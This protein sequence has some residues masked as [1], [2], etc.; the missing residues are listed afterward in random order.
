MEEESKHESINNESSGSRERNP[1]LPIP[2]STSIRKHFTNMR[3]RSHSQRHRS[4]SL[5]DHT[6]PNSSQY[7]GLTPV[8]EELTQMHLT[9]SVKKPKD[10]FLVTPHATPILLL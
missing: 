4:A 10:D 3:L 8:I 5:Q 7:L 1:Q 6:P 9:S 2:W